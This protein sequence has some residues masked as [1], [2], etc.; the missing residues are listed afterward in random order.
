M[1]FARAYKRSDGWYLQAISETTV[2]IGMG[3]PPRI[4][5]GVD[6]S[7]E[8]LSQ[9]VLEALA[10]SQQGVPH[11]PLEELEDTFKPMLELAGVK[12]WAAFARR[13]L[14]VG[15][16]ADDQWITFEPWENKGAKEGF[17]SIDGQEVRVRI[18]SSPAQ[19]GAAIEKAFAVCL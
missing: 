9:A 5:L 1:K 8:A 17:V 11:P 13:T 15:I 6:A 18:D 10:G 19:I 3:T 2:G 14:S 7:L 4:K 16:R 12:T